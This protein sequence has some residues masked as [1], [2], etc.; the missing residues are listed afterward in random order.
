[1][2]F[3]DSLDNL[4]DIF[5]SFFFNNGDWRIKKKSIVHFFA[6]Q[7]QGCNIYLQKAWEISYLIVYLETLYKSIP[8]STFFH[9]NSTIL[10]GWLSILTKNTFNFSNSTDFSLQNSL[11]FSEQKKFFNIIFFILNE[12]FGHIW[13][14]YLSIILKFN[15]AVG[16]K[17][18]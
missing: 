12:R 3:Y 10:I 4:V 15:L 8:D 11:I 18:L 14:T 6:Q 5:F 7:I 17:I 1:M 2:K 9:R 13:Q 16:E